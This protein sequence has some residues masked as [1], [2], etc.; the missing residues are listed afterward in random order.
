MLQPFFER[1]DTLS[2]AMLLTDVAMQPPKGEKMQLRGTS[3]V[4]RVDRNCK[5]NPIHESSLLIFACERVSLVV[6]S[7]MQKLQDMS[8][9]PCVSRCCWSASVPNSNCLKWQ[10]SNGHFCPFDC[11]SSLSADFFA[12]QASAPSSKLSADTQVSDKGLH[13]HLSMTNSRGMGFDEC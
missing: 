13:G 5:R 10:A 4:V 1:M 9:A 6:F 3:R 11:P 2:S 7:S 12:S 8:Y